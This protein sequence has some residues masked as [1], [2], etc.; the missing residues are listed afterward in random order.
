VLIVQRLKTSNAKGQRIWFDASLR[1][2]ERGGWVFAEAPQAF[3]AVHVVNGLTLWEADDVAQHHEGRGR[4]DLG[5]WLKC[6]DEF[7]PIVIEVVRKADCENFAQFQRATL[8]NRL[9][10]ENGRLE[11][12]SRLN[13]TT[14]TLY[15]DYSHPPLVDGQPV[16]YAP[17]QVYDSPF[18]QSDFGSGVVRIGKGEQS[19]VLD[20]NE[21]RPDDQ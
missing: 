13:G 21:T 4:T 16:N 1:R 9:Q 12:A 5:M 18:L 11:Y 10:W 7:S 6:E 2:V 20:F 17:R 14:L 15:T 19:L 3:A 8:A